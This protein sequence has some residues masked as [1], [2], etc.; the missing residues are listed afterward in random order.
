MVIAVARTAPAEEV[1]AAGLAALMAAALA[2]AVAVAGTF[3]LTSAAT[4]IA[5]L[6]AVA[7]ANAVA[8]VGTLQ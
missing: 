1:T 3:Q 8:A 6:M 2:N 4:A 5:A 7:L